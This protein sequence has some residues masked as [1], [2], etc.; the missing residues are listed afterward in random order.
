MKQTHAVY[1]L[2]VGLAALALTPDLFAQRT[3]TATATLSNDVVFA[4][5]VTHGG[6]GY[7][8]P[9]LVT[10]GGGGGSGATAE[11]TV[12]GGA[13]TAITVLTGGSGYTSA[14][15][16]GIAPPDVPI[17]ALV[18]QLIPQLTISGQIGS[19]NQIETANT[20]GNTNIWTSLAK[21]VLTQSPQIWYD[22][23][24]LPN[25]Q[26]YYRAIAQGGSR[27]LAPAGF[28]WLPGG[29]FMMGSPDTEQDRQSN[30]G[31]QT[32]VTLARGFYL[33]QHE[34]TQ[35]EYLDVVG[36]N[37]SYFTG[38]TN[39]PVENVTWFEA[40]NYCALLTAGEHGA[41][42]IPTNWVYRL[43]TE[44]EWEFACRAGTT[45]RFYY[46]DDPGYTLLG[47]YAWYSGNS[48]STTHAVGQKRPNRWGL[49]DMHGNV[50]EWCLDWYGAYPGGSVTDP[51]GPPTGSYRVTRAG[52]WDLNVASYCRSAFRY[53]SYPGYRSYNLGFRVALVSVP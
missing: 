21:V 12:A 51:T 52:G 31:P 16:V 28:V 46:G 44:A 34:V 4:I 24:S 26:R 47:E 50:W 23:I 42:R 3:A 1:S 2:A 6:E 43:P 38:N 5:T 22:T 45:N 18:V 25:V 9:P 37:P 17:T 41:G 48:G 20:V 19:T 11:A 49:Y 39:R 53:G 14:P 33:C 35:G 40:T 7:T 8:T 29:R 13:V 10:I 27:P 15:D 36:S 30:E 32:E